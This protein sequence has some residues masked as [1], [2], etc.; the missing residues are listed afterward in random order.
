MKKLLILSALL[1]LPA[2]ANTSPNGF[3]RGFPTKETIKETRNNENFQNALTAYRFWYPTVSMEAGLI[4]MN[5]LGI[6]FNKEM[7]YMKSDPKGKIF[8]PNADTPYGAINLDISKGPMVVEIPA[9]PYIGFIN[10]HHYRW[11]GDIGL[12]SPQGDKGG[13]V[14]IVS[15]EYKGTVPE[16]FTKVVSETN[17]IL[18]GIRI[19]PSDGDADVALDKLI[20]VKV[21]PFKN[22]DYHESSM[23]YVNLSGKTY[24][25]TILTYEDNIKF[26]RHLHKVINEEPVVETYSP[27]YGILAQLGIEKGKPFRPNR[28]MQS[29]L[30]QATLEGKKQMLVSAFGSDREDRIVWKDRKWE[31]VGLVPNV[32]FFET[33]SGIDLE[34]KDRWFAQAIGTSAAMFKRT[35]GAGSLYWL[36]LKDNKENYLDGG[37]TYKLSVPGPVPAK[38]FWSVSVYDNET[39]AFIETD[40][41]RA[42][43]RS[44]FELKDMKTAKSYDLYFGPKAPAGKE[45]HWIKTVP[46]KG[47]FAYFRIYGPEGKAFNGKWKPGDFEEVKGIDQTAQSE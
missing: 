33:Q 46:G 47:W 28:Q 45:N 8:T 31:W 21:Y 1:S 12:P 7:V 18:V 10:D 44:L 9:G 35:E 37:K 40:Q 26:W 5:R 30:E 2:F 24:D 20:D 19:L 3:E 4:E 15:K 41:N 38:L 17:K 43:I 29:I 27:M 39:R 6:S 22:V 14:L 13:K 36:G 32:S 11:I 23:K 34:A 42:A 16:G 25:M